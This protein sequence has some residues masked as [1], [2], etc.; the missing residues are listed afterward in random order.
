[1]QMDAIVGTISPMDMNY[2]WRLPDGQTDYGEAHPVEVR[3]EPDFTLSLL[4]QPPRKVAESGSA[5]APSIQAHGFP[6]RP[7]AKTCG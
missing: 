1:M 3:L 7:I 2:P 5:G 4:P 6:L